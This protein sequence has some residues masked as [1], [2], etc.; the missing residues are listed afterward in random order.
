MKIALLAE[1][2]FPTLGGIQEHVHHLALSLMRKGHDVRVLTGLPRVQTWRGPRDESWVVRLGRAHVYRA[3]GGSTT[4]TFGPQIARKL[5]ETLRA[6]NFDLVH[7]HGPCDF[8]LPALLCQMYRGP[9]VATLHSPIN[10]PSPLRRLAAPYYRR[11]LGRCDAVIAVSQ[12]AR[13]AMARY[14]DFTARIVPNGVDT[15]ALAAGT[16]LRHLQDGRINVLMLGRLEPRNGP[17][18]MFRALPR[19]LARFPN[20]R[21]LVAGEGTKGVAAHEAQA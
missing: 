13:D 7:M 12:A 16:P 9:L 18:I 8:G 10:S 6:E 11:V 2:Y 20:L 1:N 15:K 19:L 14:A 3:L 5:H 21:L 4:A 17:D